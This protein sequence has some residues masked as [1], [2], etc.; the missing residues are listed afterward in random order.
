M[1][2]RSLYC[3]K[4]EVDRAMRFSKET[5]TIDVR[6][7]AIEIQVPTWTCSICAEAIADEAFG[8]P[9]ER[10]YAVYR[11]KNGLLS[12]T[13]IRRIRERWG[14]SQVAFAALLGMS[15]ATINRYEAG[16][17]QQQKEDELIRACDDPTRMR[18]LLNRQGHLLTERQRE[19][20]EATLNASTTTRGNLLRLLW[21]EPMPVENS[22][23]SGYRPFEFERYA[24]VVSWFCAQ[25]PTVTQTKLYKLLFYA[26]Y[27]CFQLT[28][29]SLT[30]SL[31]KKMPGGPVPCGF[32]S[33][34]CQLE[35]N[36]LVR[37]NEV[38]F[39]NGNTGEVFQQGPKSTEIQF[40]FSEDEVRVLTFVRDQLGQ[41]KPSEISDKSHQE[42]AWKNTPDKQVI[43]YE[44]AM[45]LS[46]NVPAAC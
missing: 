29:R 38:T 17:I 33:L 36:E 43:S 32:S 15:Q 1:M 27:L 41:L 9:V 12:P 35:E 30:G 14:L 3:P 45:E 44:R 37:V 24:A 13:E 20:A 25:V 10:A 4:C 11:E 2:E 40:D 39:Q 34:R 46:L 28:S 8:D 7:E 6:G 16:S 18:D 31:Y 5:Q 21:G 23:R 26:D 22:L 19:V 42:T